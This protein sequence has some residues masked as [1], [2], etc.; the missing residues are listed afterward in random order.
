M[1]NGDVL[2]G[3]YISDAGRTEMAD[4]DIGG[5]SPELDARGYWE[6]VKDQLD[7]HWVKDNVLIMEQEAAQITEEQIPENITAEDVSELDPN[8]CSDTHAPSCKG[9][10]GETEQQNTLSIIHGTF[11]N[12]NPT[13]CTGNAPPLMKI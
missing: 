3:D 10:E 13:A 4:Q 9:S 5:F 1:N 12:T 11:E 8:L 2:N 7:E 6:A